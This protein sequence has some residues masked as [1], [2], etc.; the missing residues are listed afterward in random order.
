[1]SDVEKHAQKYIVDEGKKNKKVRNID[2]LMLFTK[3]HK[4]VPKKM[5]KEPNTLCLLTIIPFEITY[6]LHD[7]DIGVTPDCDK[8]KKS[9]ENVTIKSDTSVSEF[10]SESGTDESDAV[11]TKYLCETDASETVSS[12]SKYD[13]D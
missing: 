5:K 3:H 8:I 10:Q 6:F 4:E 11:E 7:N 2:D 1:M 9:I 12:E 13:E